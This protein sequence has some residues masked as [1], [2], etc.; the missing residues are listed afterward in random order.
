MEIITDTVMKTI[1]QFP[2]IDI[3]LTLQFRADNMCIDS[4]LD[5]HEQNFAVRSEVFL[6]INA[7]CLIKYSLTTHIS[8]FLSP[9]I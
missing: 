6:G 8:K 1:L 5:N 7:V 3:L 2:P 4:F 9:I